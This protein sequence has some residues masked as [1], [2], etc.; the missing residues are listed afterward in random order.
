MNRLRALEIIRQSSPGMCIEDA[1]QLIDEINSLAKFEIA[2]QA[3]ARFDSQLK[4]IPEATVWASQ[5]FTTEELNGFMIQ[6]IKRLR[7]NFDGLGLKEA[8]AIIDAL[9][10][11]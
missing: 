5:E 1:I 11:S 4:M 10:L 8:R 7:Q 3:N 2:S 9:R 6:C